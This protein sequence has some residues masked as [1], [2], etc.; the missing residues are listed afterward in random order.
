M[1][2]LILNDC[3]ADP[4][5]VRNNILRS[6]IFIESIIT[7]FSIQEAIDQ[8]NQHG[9]HLIVIDFDTDGAFSML[10]ALKNHSH[11]IINI[12]RNSPQDYFTARLLNKRL[13]DI[14]VKTTLA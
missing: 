2:I 4:V 7:C 9:S 8:T 6:D 5:S 12:A 1:R 14:V 13:P 3:V 10:A 11:R